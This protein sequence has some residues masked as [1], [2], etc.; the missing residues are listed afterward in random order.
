MVI[1]CYGYGRF[2]TEAID[3]VAASHGVIPEVIVI[4]D[5]SGDGASET[6]RRYMATHD[7]VPIKLVSRHANAGLAAARNLGF[8]AARAP[9]VFP[10]D[11]DNSIYPHC[12]SRLSEALLP[13]AAAA[14][15]GILE[16]FNDRQ[17]LLS[18]VPWDV[19]RLVAGPYIDASA[20]IRKQAWAAVGGYCT[21][22]SELYGWEDY[23]LWLSFA[24]H[25]MHA[26]LVPEI[27]VR[28]RSHGSSMIH[29]TNIETASMAALLRKRHHR[30][31]WPAEG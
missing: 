7:W 13:S 23:D 25:D 31:T 6:V 24:N 15:Y 20:L 2:V 29:T 10:L 3:S 21:D 28:Y 14:A 16:V 11:A 30:L 18:A 1:P 17:G 4:D 27:L 19:R 5:H 12:L 26:V 22:N 8:A 9:F